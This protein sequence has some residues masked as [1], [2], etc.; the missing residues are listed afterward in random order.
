MVNHD[1]TVQWNNL[2][3]QIEPS[4]FRISFAKCRVTV[5]DHLDNTLSVVYGPHVIGHYDA[6]GRSLTRL[7][8]AA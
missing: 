6:Y 4:K 2:I 3:L 7:K 5:H 1:N 8:K